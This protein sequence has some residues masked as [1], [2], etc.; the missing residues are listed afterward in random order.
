[1]AGE[2]ASTGL[3]A[4]RDK[5]ADERL[6]RRH[7]SRSELILWLHQRSR[8]SIIFGGVCCCSWRFELSSKQTLVSVHKDTKHLR[9]RLNVLTPRLAPQPLGMLL[10]SI[11]GWFSRVTVAS[12]SSRPQVEN[13]ATAPNRVAAS[14]AELAG[15][16]AAD[17]TSNSGLLMF[18][19]GRAPS[20][21]AQFLLSHPPTANGHKG[22]DANAQDPNA[23]ALGML[24][25][26]ESRPALHGKWA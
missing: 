10:D 16:S 23:R 4:A 6:L 26:L 13:T 11:T 17:S 8:V 3:L 25:V 18:A 15:R 9:S 12:M 22:A 2:A 14:V 19:A 5:K 20:D 7:L 21:V 24:W 1:M